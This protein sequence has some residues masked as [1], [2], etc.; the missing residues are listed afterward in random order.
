MAKEVEELST[1]KLLVMPG[2]GLA[3]G[4]VWMT[5]PT[6]QGCREGMCSGIRAPSTELGQ[7]SAR[8]E[9]ISKNWSWAN[10]PSCPLPPD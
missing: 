3:M 5:V 6:R 4:A 1:G 8:V 2:G 7:T 9:S 10:F